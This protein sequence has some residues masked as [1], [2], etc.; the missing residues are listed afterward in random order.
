[1]NIEKYNDTIIRKLLNFSPNT[2]INIT[3]EEIYFLC[4]TVQKI[5][6]EQNMLIEINAPVIVCGDIHGQYYDLLRLIKLGGCPPKSNYIF[7]G[8][9]VDRGYNS[10]EVI[11]LC[12]LKITQ[13]K[14]IYQNIYNH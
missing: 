4:S 5:F 6:E 3:E 11:T 13:I 14:L 8:D 2:R 12:M 7:L 1:M 10:I 9:Y